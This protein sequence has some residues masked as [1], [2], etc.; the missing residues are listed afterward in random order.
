MRRRHLAILAA[1]WLGFLC[2][3][4]GKETPTPE[5]AED[6]V[7]KLTLGEGPCCLAVAADSVYAL[8]H[9]D[10][11]LQQ[12]DPVSNEV[13]APIPVDADVM[14]PLG[15]RLLLTNTDTSKSS[16][17][18][19]K[20]QAV[21]PIRGFISQ[22]NF[23]FDG[24][25]LWLGSPQS[26]ELVRMDPRS[27]KIV[28]RLNFPEVPNFQSLFFMESG[29]VWA[30]TWDGELL[31]LDMQ[32]ERVSSRPDP[33]A[34]WPATMVAAVGDLLYAVCMDAGELVRMDGSTGSV[35][36]L[37]GSPGVVA[38]PEGT[39]WLTHGPD[40][41]DQLDPLTGETLA[42]FEIPLVPGKDFIEQY[43]GGLTSGFGSLWV[44]VW[45]DTGPAGQVVRFD[46][47]QNS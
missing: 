33:C 1:C 9:R 25:S 47:A 6:E 13:S 8:N 38:T 19:P 43:G 3:A 26:G 24:S 27:A 16:I 4:C 40:A 23:G 14:A 20:S 44:T 45:A 21:L 29:S 31:G 34:P 10:R 42:S 17:Y 11:S 15:E 41:V 39:L 30:V 35:E 32:E 36:E 18:V 37:G 22:G 2:A 12:I 28:E 7:V 5:E 46:L